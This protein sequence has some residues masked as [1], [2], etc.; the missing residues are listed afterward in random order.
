MLSVQE[1][2]IW[3]NETIVREIKEELDSVIEPIKYV[4]FSNHEYTDLEKPFSITMYG[5]ECKLIEGELKLSEHTASNW[6]TE[7]EL[8][9]VDFAAADI[10]FIEM[11]K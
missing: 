1:R 6:V 7:D 9:N 3:I 4:G 11:I 5:Y 2:N 10:P 8:K